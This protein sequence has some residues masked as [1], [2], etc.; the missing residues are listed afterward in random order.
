MN[1]YWTIG[2]VIS[3]LG[4]IPGL[5]FLFNFITP[6]KSLSWRAACKAIIEL[7][8][9]IKQSYNPEFVMGVYI[10]KVAGGLL[11]GEMM[12][13]RL[14]IPLIGVVLADD[15]KGRRSFLRLTDKITS[16]SRILLVDDI[17]F[18]GRTLSKIYD[19]LK[20]EKPDLEIRSAV[21]VAN[22]VIVSNKFSKDRSFKPNYH[23]IKTKESAFEMPWGIVNPPMTIL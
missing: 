12:A 7:S 6:R 14:G 20:K 10:E 17:I 21:L 18:T 22:E 9:E 4:G 23:K 11:L 8:D 13:A 15:D 3:I 19:I 5:Y 1:F 2:I 16:G